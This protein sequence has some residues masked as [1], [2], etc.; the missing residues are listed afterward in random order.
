M[1]NLKLVLTLVALVTLNGCTGMVGQVAGLTAAGNAKA[2]AIVDRGIA[3]AGV[4]ADEYLDALGAVEAFL[5]RKLAR[6]RSGRCLT[7]LP[8]ME[9]FAREGKAEA[10]I[11]ERDCHVTFEFGTV[12]VRPKG[13]AE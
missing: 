10:A 7:T 3:R 1:K 8:S 11:L 12:V 2:E 5:E 6:V 13:D 9:R 4:V